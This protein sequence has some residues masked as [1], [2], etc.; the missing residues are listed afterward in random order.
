MCGE[1]SMKNA[2]TVITCAVTGGGNT[3]QKSDKVPVTPRQIAAACLEASKAGAAVVHVHVR[4]PKTGLASRDPQL[5]REVVERVRDS[6]TNVIVN[7]TTGMGADWA[8]SEANPSVGTPESD[9][10]GPM[11]RIV[12]VDQLRPDIC[13]LDV[14]SMNFGDMVFVNTVDHVRK[15]AAKIE[16]WGVKPELEVFDLGHARFAAQLVSEGLISAPP[17]CQVCLGVPWG[18]AADTFSMLAMVQAL[19]KGAVW[20]GFGIG[21]AQAPMVAQAYLLGGHVRVGLED[22]LYL[23]PGRLATNGELVERAVNTLRSVGADIATPDE[24]RAIFGLEGGGP[25]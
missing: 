24:A 22:N 6:G 9:I 14:G 10:V 25:R 2:K 13:S 17:L 15:M 21:R 8:P 7:L 5:Y 19:P 20:S 18:A 12:H 11:E 1:K 3:V 4:D 23:G 16:S